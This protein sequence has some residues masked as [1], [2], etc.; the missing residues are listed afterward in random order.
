MR[1]RLLIGFKT[2]EFI[3][4]LP[5]AVKRRGAVSPATLAM[6]KRIPVTMPL[7]P[8]GRI[9]FKIVLGYETPKARD[10][11]LRL[12]GIS[13]RVCSVVVIMTGSI[14]R[15]RATPPE[16]AENDPIETTSQI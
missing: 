8:A 12:P 11:S 13:F 9:T 16:S 1:G 2:L 15:P 7:T 6:L 14:I 3:K 10:A 5:K 4:G